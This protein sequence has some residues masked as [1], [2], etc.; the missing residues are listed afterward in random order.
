MVDAVG[1]DACILLYKKKEAPSVQNLTDINIEIDNPVF[2]NHI[3]IEDTCAIVNLRE[4]KCLKS[5]K[6]VIHFKEFTLVQ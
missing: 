4:T 6:F 5:V 3:D 1:A 2:V